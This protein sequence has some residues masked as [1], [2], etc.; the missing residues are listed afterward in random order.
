MAGLGRF[1]ILFASVLSSVSFFVSSFGVKVG[2][3]ALTRAALRVKARKN[4]SSVSSRVSLG[5][6]GFKV[7]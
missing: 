1:F 6:E 4:G 3:C 5:E 7:F 2:A